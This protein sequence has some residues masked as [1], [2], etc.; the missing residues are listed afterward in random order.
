MKRCQGSPER[1]GSPRTLC[2]LGVLGVLELG[3]IAYALSDSAASPAVGARK[4]T[5]RCDAS[6]AGVRVYPGPSARLALATAYDR[7]Y[8][9]LAAISVR[10]KR[11]YAR[12]HGLPLYVYGPAALACDRPASWSKVLAVGAAL[13]A[14]HEWVA[15]LD[16][17][18]VFARLD[19]ALD[20]AAARPHVAAAMRGSTAMLVIATDGGGGGGRRRQ[21]NNGV[22][23]LRRSAWASRFLAT[24]WNA[25]AFLA[26]TPGV[27]NSRLGD[28]RAFEWALE[29]R[30]GDGEARRGA[31]GAA[32]AYVPQAELNSY[33]ATFRPGELVV[34][35]A[36]CLAGA[37][38]TVAGCAAE[39]QRWAAV[40][41]EAEGGG[42]SAGAQ[43]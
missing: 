27:R 32:V 17:D 25:T 14:G 26:D 29:R 23:V 6:A 35:I 31:A 11:A 3:L 12:R 5:A 2:A 8:A 40:E 37:R 20:D 19:G 28:Q 41:A 22:F 33:P 43:P 7:F 1:P 10:N 38:R 42:G 39:L 34:H 13:D 15:W 24:V 4:A 30:G 21:I 16:A 9:P 36:G 18:A